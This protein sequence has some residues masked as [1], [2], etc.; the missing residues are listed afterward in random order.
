LTFAVVADF[1]DAAAYRDYDTDQAHNALR[2]EPARA[3]QIA[4]LQFQP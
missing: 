1:I 3:K 4:R 2:A